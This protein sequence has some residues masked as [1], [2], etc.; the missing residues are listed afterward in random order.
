MLNAEKK[1]ITHLIGPGLLPSNG[2]AAICLLS[3]FSGIMRVSTFSCEV[4]KV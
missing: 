1:N 3:T 4:R 2:P